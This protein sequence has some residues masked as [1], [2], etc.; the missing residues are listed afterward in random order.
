ML[1]I[2]PLGVMLHNINSVKDLTLCYILGPLTIFRHGATKTLILNDHSES[3][4]DDS[5]HD[6][7]EGNVKNH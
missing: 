4:K 2:G 7:T 6:K 5:N 3:L 1:L